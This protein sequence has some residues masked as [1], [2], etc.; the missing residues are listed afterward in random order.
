MQLRPK[1]TSADE[2]VKVVDS[3]GNFNYTKPRGYY[4]RASFTR[5]LLNTFIQEQGLTE[6]LPK[7]QNFRQ[8]LNLETA[9]AS[10]DEEV[11]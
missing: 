2:V 7:L 6:I 9:P 1:A 5:E 4:L 11:F 8:K 10:D 3:E